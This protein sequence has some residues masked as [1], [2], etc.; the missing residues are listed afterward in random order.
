M[1][2]QPP[3]V[4]TGS[5][6]FNLKQ[7]DSEHDFYG[8]LIKTSVFTASMW[9]LPEQKQGPLNND[10]TLFDFNGVASYNLLRGWTVTDGTDS[11]TAGT[12]IVCDGANWQHVL[13]TTDGLAWTAYVNG[14]E[15]L[16]GTLAPRLFN[17]LLSGDTV[18]LGGRS[19]GQTVPID[20]H[21][22]GGLRNF[23]MYHRPVEFA[24]ANALYQQGQIGS[25]P[26]LRG[27]KETM[28]HTAWLGKHR[29]FTVAVS[30]YA[31]VESER[32]LMNPANGLAS[33]TPTEPT[34]RQV[35]LGV[36]A[37]GTVVTDDP[38]TAVYAFGS[39]ERA[40]HALLPGTEYRFYVVDLDETGQPQSLAQPVDVVTAGEFSV[41]GVTVSNVSYDD[42]RLDWN[43]A[44]PA[45]CS[46]NLALYRETDAASTAVTHT[47]TRPVAGGPVEFQPPLGPLRVG[48]RVVLDVSSPTMAGATLQF[49]T[50][51]GD[52][53]PHNTITL[54]APGTSGA[55]TLFNP[56]A[57]GEAWAFLEETGFQAGAWTAAVPVEGVTTLEAH[58]GWEAP[59][60]GQTELLEKVC[61]PENTTFFSVPIHG[62]EMEAGQFYHVY[63]YNDHPNG[64]LTPT[65]SH[66]SFQTRYYDLES[67]HIA[68]TT[69][70]A[71]TLA[72]TTEEPIPQSQ[73]PGSASLI[74]AAYTTPQ[75]WT[76]G[77]ELYKS[78]LRGE[79]DSA[80]YVDGRGTAGL[81]SLAFGDGSHGET[82]LLSDVRYF[83]Y[84]A[85]VS[86]AGVV[87]PV[88]LSDMAPTSLLKSYVDSG[89]RLDAAIG[90]A[91]GASAGQGNFPVIITGAEV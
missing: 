79:P 61:V 19:S 27:R 29:E 57:R 80:V 25:E 72:W 63:S 81:T 1:T 18:V 50:A 7:I 90:E 10:H 34:A 48:D 89:H 55:R 11:L 35:M 47:A 59:A 70:T 85:C 68:A 17:Y 46:T 12:A 76:Q 84:A 40:E 78:F 77:K 37:Y 66:V 42:Y 38:R 44:A 21:Y 56:R 45:A 15:E 5:S 9:I 54:H 20:R 39:Q 49:S 53:A 74:I 16:S 22:V 58:A 41:K 73:Q 75:G 71:V 82:P 32:N 91:G 2:T 64:M 23:Q 87:S 33:P 8:D 6:Y 24:E 36:G 69:E 88:V 52:T 83:I 30:A 31:V 28:V 65:T 4:F 13:I 26:A 86:P 3:I 14:V 62:V 67:F 60:P 43:P 51:E